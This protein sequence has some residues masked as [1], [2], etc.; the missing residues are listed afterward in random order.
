[1]AIVAPVPTDGGVVVA[2]FLMVGTIAFTI[3]STVALY[4][5][6]TRE[7][8]SNHARLLRLLSGWA[9]ISNSFIHVLLTIYILSNAA[10]D[11]VYWIEERKLGGIEGPVGLAVLNLLAGL[12]ALRSYS[13]KFPLVWN[14]FVATAGTFMPIVWLR[15]LEVGLKEWPYE[16]IFIWFAIFF[17]ELLSVACSVAHVAIVPNYC[18]D[19]SGGKKNE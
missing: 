3:C 16:V 17:F 4:E 15:F 9:N 8:G 2:L 7:K 13:S 12:S 18:A 1:M 6:S 10:N 5:C 11:S 14:V 19:S